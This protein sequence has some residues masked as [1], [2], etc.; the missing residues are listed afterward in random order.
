MA[1]LTIIWVGGAVTR[2]TSRLNRVGQHRRV[3]PAKVLDLVRRLGPHYNNEQIAFILNA[4]R[5]RTGQDNAFTASGRRR[6]G[7]PMVKLPEPGG[8]G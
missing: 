7:G 6:A 2:V 8:R 1:D 3:A 5:L 4:K